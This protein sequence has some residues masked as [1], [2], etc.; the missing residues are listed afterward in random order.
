MNS[1]IKEAT[2]AN[3]G[4]VGYATNGVAIFGPYNSGCCDATFNEIQ[5]M[6]YW[7]G[8]RDHIS[9]ELNMIFKV[10]RPR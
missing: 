5:T 1:W 7:K 8:I 6:D 10:G 9:K 2:D 3:Q 4:A